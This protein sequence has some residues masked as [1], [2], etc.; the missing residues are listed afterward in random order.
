M[1]DR[2]G[3]DQMIETK[4]WIF[5][6]VPKT[7]GSSISQTFGAV[8]RARPLHVPLFIM[9]KERRGRFA[10]G[11]IRNPWARMVS[12]Y[13]FMCQRKLLPGDGYDQGAI[14][15]MGFKDW[16]INDKFW[17]AQDKHWASEDLLPMQ[18]RQ[19]MWWLN[20]CDR[21]LKYE[22]LDLEL[23]KLRADLKLP[24]RGLPRVN[25]TRG[26][27][28]RLEYDDES[29]EFVRT[30]FADDIHRGGYSFE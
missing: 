22:N 25:A 26:R 1:V 27:D 9:E 21:I 18:T 8:S 13:R 5:I 29:A 30:T 28:W 12:Y 20:G 17:M 10:W 24:P 15:S 6:H 2:N 23:R 11:V 19:Q 4:G 16:L 14:I 7:A 3:S